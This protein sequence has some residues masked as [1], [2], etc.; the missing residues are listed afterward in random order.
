MSGH[1]SSTAT[2]WGPMRGYDQAT[3]LFL[4][5]IL[6]APEVQAKKMTGDELLQV[7][8][9]GGRGGREGEEGYQGHQLGWRGAAS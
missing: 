2:L 4:S 5:S 9:E 3:F 7:R 1:L 8:G 6:G